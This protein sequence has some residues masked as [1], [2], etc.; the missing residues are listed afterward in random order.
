M[1]LPHPER[2]RPAY[3]QDP[4][5]TVVECKS[6]SAR[7]YRF[8]YASVGSGYSWVDRLAWPDDELDHWLSREDV[9]ILVMHV[10][11]TPC[12]YAELVAEP[13]E[14]GTEV[15]Y[16]GVFP[17]FHGRGLG[18]YLLSVAV[19]HAFDDGARRVWLSTRSTDGP[20]AIAN[21]EARGFSVYRTEWEPAPNYP[22]IET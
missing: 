19:Q 8:L 2:F 3:A 15:K 4:S 17:E 10:D 18:K 13:D 11:G 22:N 7:F 14:P 21:Y 6:T 16:F 20:H 1:H 9:T 12:G 5:L